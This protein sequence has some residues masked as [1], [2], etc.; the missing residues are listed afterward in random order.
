MGPGQL[1]TGT[2]ESGKRIPF[3]TRG[4]QVQILPLRPKLCSKISS[5]LNRKNCPLVYVHSF[6]H[7]FLFPARN[8]KP[9]LTLVG[10]STAFPAMPEREP[11]RTTQHIN[12]KASP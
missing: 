3:G 10:A 4:S 8:R 9:A 1:A 7:R 11:P 12:K 5:F 2:P 6:V